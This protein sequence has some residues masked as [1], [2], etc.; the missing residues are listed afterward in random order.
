MDLDLVIHD[1]TLVTACETTQADLG[2]REGRI[3]IIGQNL[4][5]KQNIDAKGLLVLPGAVDPHVHLEMFTGVTTSSDDWKTG[6]I[7]AA[8]G[9][10]T[11]SIDFIEPRHDQTLMEGL[12]E[13][14]AQADNKTFIDYALHM[15][16]N[17]ADDKTLSEI[18]EVV[19]AGVT[20]FKIYTT[21]ALKMEDAEILVGF[22][23]MRKAGALPVVHAE[24][25]AIVQWMQKTLL[26]AG[27]TSPASHP[28]SRP[29]AAEG[30]AVE[31]VISLAEI[32]GSPVY[33]VHVSTERGAKSIARARRRGMKVFGET[34]PQYLL[35]N[36]SLFDSLD[37][38]AAKFICSP[39]LRKISDNDALWGL[40]AQ[41]D[42]QSIG[43]DHCPFFYKGQK[44]IG[45]A[46]FTEIPG[47]IPGIEP[48]LALMHTFGVVT[49]KITLNKWVDACCSAPARLFGLY[50]R[51]GCLMPGADAD[52]VLF[53][54]KKELILTKNILHENVDYTP[55]EGMALQGY[56]V[57]TILRGDVLVNHGK[58]V[59]KVKG[60]FLPCALP[61]LE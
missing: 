54:Q 9:G 12:A 38:E 18:P 32:A 61:I 20:S 14:R 4:R 3:A 39:P 49:G 5:G 13:R 1:G 48:R 35:L 25:H 58:V 60:S 27:K 16:F 17:R 51:K 23:A 30:E 24:N 37:F 52:I 10:T 2:I 59:G 45:R 6:T 33:I 28:L 46:R 50:P 19:A 11:T 42:L 55:Y 57:M 44:D 40:L 41:G 36:D 34:C 56:P 22:V 31:R 29:A 47:G 21:Y 43:T 53:D 26:D 8:C 15:T 7:A